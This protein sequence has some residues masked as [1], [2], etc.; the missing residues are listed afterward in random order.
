MH[1]LRYAI[2]ADPSGWMEM[3]GYKLVEPTAQW[4]LQRC[5]EQTT[6]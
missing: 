4:L 2:L 3:Q 6:A 5:V 1:V